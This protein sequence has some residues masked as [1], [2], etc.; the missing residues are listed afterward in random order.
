M[1][2]VDYDLRI[3]GDLHEAASL[4]G[5]LAQPVTSRVKVISN[6]KIDENR[7]PQDGRFRAKLFDRDIDFRVATFPTRVED[8][9]IFVDLGGACKIVEETAA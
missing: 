1:T 7:V 4:P 2:R 6:L 5:E 3:D 9:I 8:G